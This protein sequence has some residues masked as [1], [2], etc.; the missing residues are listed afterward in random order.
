MYNALKDIHGCGSTKLHVDVSDAWNINLYGTPAGDPAIW[1]IFPRKQLGEL[2]RALRELDS[3]KGISREGNA[4]L[5]HRIFLKDSDLEFLAEK[6]IRPY[7]IYQRP[8]DM[9]FIPAGCA[10]QVIPHN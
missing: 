8:G 9:V 10:H 7:I 1:L 3:R 2:A 5:Q 6:G 4:A